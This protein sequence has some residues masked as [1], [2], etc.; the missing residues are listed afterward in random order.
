[1]RESPQEVDKVIIHTI[2]VKYPVFKRSSGQKVVAPPSFL[3]SQH[4]IGLVDLLETLL[5]L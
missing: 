4:V 2:M 5:A 1:L 3:I